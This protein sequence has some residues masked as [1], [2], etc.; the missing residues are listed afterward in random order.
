MNDDEVLFVETTVAARVIDM[1]DIAHRHSWMISIQGP[2]GIGK[3][4]AVEEYARRAKAKVWRFTARRDTAAV[5]PMMRALAQQ[6]AGTCDVR[7]YENVRALLEA[8]SWARLDRGPLLVIDE[9]QNLN[10]DTLEEL[11]SVH[12]EGKIGIAFIGNHTFVDRH[13]GKRSNL[14][15]SP[16]FVSRLQLTM[17]LTG[18]EPGDAEAVARLHGITGGGTIKRLALLA[19][20][21]RGLRVLDGIVGLAN[22]HA[23]GAPPKA[24]DFDFALSIL[25]QT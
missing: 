15:A 10:A 8:A 9:A 17:D 6:F 7:T 11:R 19:R 21:P 3:T 22:E 4:T 5:G 12:D 25:A 20:G 13:N 14:V 16:Q 1:L 18:V 23:A 2:P 24:E